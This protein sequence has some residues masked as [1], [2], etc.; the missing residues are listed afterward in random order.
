MENRS[1]TDYSSSWIP[2]SKTIPVK[3]LPSQDQLRWEILSGS[4]Y[5]VYANKEQREPLWWYEK[6]IQSLSREANLIQRVKVIT[7]MAWSV[8]RSR[9]M[10]HWTSSMRSWL[11]MR[12]MMIIVGIL[13]PR[14]FYKRMWLV[15]KTM[16]KI[17]RILIRRTS[18]KRMWLV[19]KII[20][21]IAISW[22]PIP[23]N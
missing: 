16:M 20:I 17:V 9:I 10:S 15:M 11:V 5:F 6:I 7:Y 13:I 12:T 8:L 2:I 18:Y 19:M 1:L 23:H 14:T 21:R 4:L 22:L 3:L